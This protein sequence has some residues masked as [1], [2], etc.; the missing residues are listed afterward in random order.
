M[1]KLWFVLLFFVASCNEKPVAS[2]DDSEFEVVLNVDEI[3]LLTGQKTTIPI[4]IKLLNGYEGDVRL[5]SANCDVGYANFYESLDGSYHMEFYGRPYVTPKDDEIRLIFASDNTLKQYRIGFKLS[6]IPRLHE[7]AASQTDTLFLEEG[8]I[9][10]FTVTP[11]DSLGNAIPKSYFDDLGISFNYGFAGFIANRFTYR[12]AEGSQVN[13][14][15]FIRMSSDIP[16]DI[17]DS[18]YPLD[19]HYSV[20]HIR[21]DMPIR[22]TYK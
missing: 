3:S 11:K 12:V 10:A 1:N 15:L 6:Y 13:F 4:E 19:F 8:E 21:K 7:L 14:I 16:N 17:N 2:T 5:L 22:I 20:G 9:E 18:T